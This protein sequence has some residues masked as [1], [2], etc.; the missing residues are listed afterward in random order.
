MD[1]QAPVSV[2]PNQKAHKKEHNVFFQ[3]SESYIREKALNYYEWS[4]CSAGVLDLLIMNEDN[5]QKSGSE[6][7]DWSHA[8]DSQEQI[9]VSTLWEKLCWKW[10]GVTASTA[11][12]SASLPALRIIDALHIGNLSA[13]WSRRG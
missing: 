1:S 10:R 5:L 4:G 6:S 9:Y 8:W 12:T 2:S 13:S 11:L 7:A 3:Y